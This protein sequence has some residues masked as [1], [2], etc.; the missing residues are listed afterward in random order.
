M[1]PSPELN[2]PPP[3][4]VLLEPGW[5]LGK[6]GTEVGGKRGFCPWGYLSSKVWSALARPKGRRETP[7]SPRRGQ[8]GARQHHYMASQPRAPGQGRV[9]PWAQ[10]NVYLAIPLSGQCQPGDTEGPE[11]M[12]TVLM[13]SVSPVTVQF[14]LRKGLPR[15]QDTGLQSTSTRVLSP[16]HPVFT[17]YVRVCACFNAGTTL[18]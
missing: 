18:S 4:T 5:F 11:R 12:T 8:G 7:H 9:G 10:F 14:S 15:V 6:A 2:L 16:R 1:Q 13:T 3:H 17:V